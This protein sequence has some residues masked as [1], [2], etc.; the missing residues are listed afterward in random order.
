[1][2]VSNEVIRSRANI[3]CENVQK[4]GCSNVLVSQN[5]PAQFKNL[6]GFFDLIVVDAPC[7]GEGLFRKEP[8]AISEWSLAN[9][10][11]CSLRQKRILADVFPAIKQNGILVYCTC[12]YNTQE[13]EENLK[14][15]ASQHAIEFISLPINP[16]WGIQ[17]TTEGGVRGY[18]FFPHRVQGEGF[19]ISVIRKLSNEQPARIK[20]KE[21]PRQDKK[22]WE[23]IQP[24][25]LD[26]STYMLHMIEENIHLIPKRYGSE[27]EFLARHL[28]LI[29]TGTA[30]GSI[31]HEKIIPDHA[32]AVSLSLNKDNVNTFEVDKDVALQFLRKETFHLPELKVGY[33]LLTFSGLGLGWVNS[34]GNRLNNLYPTNWRIRMK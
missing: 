2:L 8:G 13:N 31:K 14:W 17:E 32:L 33:V 1:L 9:V 21:L 22:V 30:M 20:Q 26:S 3:L 28:N 23:K 16:E 4:W 6:N 15:L 27:I 11:L 24:W 25:I 34:L 18:R 5:D 7:S 12:T 10:E 19:F 29:Q